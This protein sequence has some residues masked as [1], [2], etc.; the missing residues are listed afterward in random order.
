MPKSGSTHH[1]KARIAAFIGALLERG[2][3]TELALAEI[4]GVS[5][6]RLAS[7]L[8]GESLPRIDKLM[9]LAEVGHVSVDDLVGGDKGPQIE[10]G[11]LSRIAISIGGSVKGSVVAGGDAYVSPRFVTPRSYQPKEG[12][13]TPA[14][15][16]ELKE[17]VEKI[18]ESEK[19]AKRRPS[20]YGAVWN[21]LNRRMG[22]TYYREIPDTEFERARTYLEQWLGRVKRLLRRADPEE[23]RRERYKAIFARATKNWGF[24]KAQVDDLILARFGKSSIR[25]LSQ[26]QLEQ[27][28][29]SMMGSKK[30]PTKPVPPE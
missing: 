2:Q 8:K 22:V 10:E 11:T 4:L 26:Q 27:L 16:R 29:N 24:T 3:V 23:W 5:H 20:S 13:L 15:A 1:L 6:G 14:H 21:A 25:D 12:D 28:Y 9:K 19:T 30:K 17:L 7:Y 18:V